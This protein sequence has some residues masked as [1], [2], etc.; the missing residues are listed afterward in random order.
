MKKVLSALALATA[1]VSAAPAFAGTIDVDSVH[2]SVFGDVS[3]ANQYKIITAYEVD[4]VSRGAV[5][6]GAF[7]L[8]SDQ[9]GALSDFL[10]FCLQPMENLNLSIDYMK[11]SNFSDTVTANLNA[12]AA[13]AWDLVTDSVSAGAFQIAAWEITTEDEGVEF[14]VNDGNFNVVSDRD[15]SNAAES[16]AQAWLDEIG[17]GN[18]TRGPKDYVVLNA[19]NTQDLL[20]NVTT[21]PLPAS[22]MMLLAGLF[23]AGAVA[24]RKARKA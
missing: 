19:A 23:G 6:A 11:G 16:Q 18:W 10:A 22:G 4:G 20:T 7:R 2:P 15:D 3:G 1:T 9:S 21:M 14:D 13:N 12:L 24:R 5:Y 8:E 17:S